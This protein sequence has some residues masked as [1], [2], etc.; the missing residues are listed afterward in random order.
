VAH[1]HHPT[2]LAAE[3]HF[4]HRVDVPVPVGGLGGTL[5]AMLAWCH[6]NC[7]AEEW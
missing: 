3:R 4:P 1:V 5:N 6:A 2:E 7:H